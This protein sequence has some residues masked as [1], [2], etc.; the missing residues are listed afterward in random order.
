M[1]LLGCSLP[2]DLMPPSE[3]NA[4]GHW[5]SASVA[6]LNDEILTS[7]GSRWDDWM[8]FSEDWYA[9]PVRDGY[10]D[11]AL[12]VLN[13]E[14]GA[15][16]L[17]VVKDPRICRI[18][19]FWFDVLTHFGCE[20][21]VAMPIRNPFEVAQSLQKRDGLD[22]GFGL[23]LWLRHVLEAEHASRGR[24][25][26]IFA[27]DQLLADWAQVSRAMEEATGL[28]WPR[29]TVLAAAEVDGFLTR[30]ARHQ[31]VEEALPLGHRS[32]L[33]VRQT[34][35]ILKRWC[36]LGE[37]PADY[38]ALDQVRAEFD[39]AAPSFGLVLLHH[40][41]REAG[42][43]QRAD[44]EGA[45]TVALEQL[46]AEIEASQQIQHALQLAL[47]ES[48]EA[49]QGLIERLELAERRP[50]LADAEQLQRALAESQ[51]AL[52]TVGEELRGERAIAA[53][54]RT[55]VDALSSRLIT[56]RTAAQNREQSLQ[57]EMDRL[58]EAAAASAA[59]AALR[60]VLQSALNESNAARQALLEQLE[61]AEARYRADAQRT[62][63]DLAQAEAALEAARHGLEAEQA[64]T[65]RL[66][67]DIAALEGLRREE[68]RG[69]QGREQGLL[70]EIARMSSELGRVAAG[71]AERE[72]LLQSLRGEIVTLENKVAEMASALLQRKEEAAQAWAEVALEQRSQALL[73]S[74]LD[75]AE[76]ERATLRDAVNRLTEE[77]GSQARAMLDAQ[78]RQLHAEWEAQQSA[79]RATALQ[80]QLAERERA[81][82]TLSGQVSDAGARAAR[83]EREMASLVQLQQQLEQHMQSTIDAVR[84]EQAEAAQVQVEAAQVR[85]EAAL[86][87]VEAV[88][89]QAKWLTDFVTF[90]RRLPRWIWLVPLG[91]RRRLIRARAER[92]GMIDY[93]AYYA[94]NPDVAQ[95]GWDALDHYAH[96][97]IFEG[98]TW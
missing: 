9:S 42:E 62:Q 33:W 11:R 55:D 89:V 27:Y 16:P 38:A 19:P 56:E 69:A 37:D 20:V 47:N 93:S 81:L 85:A 15:S 67:D 5:E 61:A 97:G 18:A 51:A 44:D 91:M 1:N 78:S 63:L 86:E 4:T 41:E 2:V 50:D 53:S 54:L 60:E 76:A 17:F 95:A 57:E 98:R 65:T 13:A 40:A 21:I 84:A 75:H 68:R 88:Q 74:A 49:R 52:K 73:R 23:L 90:N 6:S 26:H 22:I 24:A 45:A 7:A 59:D 80:E 46:R 35:T 72:A 71:A 96:H 77:L 64:A 34:Y 36:E 8:P 32:P 25:R 12:G 70:G 58:S 66:R 30:D 29:K 10:R 28:V 79:S 48:N 87:Q 82:V 83:Y 94:A 39:V 43:T 14:F 92:T 3:S 31:N